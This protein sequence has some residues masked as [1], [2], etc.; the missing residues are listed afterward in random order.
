MGRAVV[1]AVT[2]S[3]ECT[4]AAAIDQGDGLSEL[5]GSDVI[6]DFTTPDAVMATLEYCLKAG[7]HCVVGTTGFDES[8]LAQVKSWCAANPKVGVLIAPNF[9]IGAVLMMHFAEIAAPYFE[10]VEIIELHHPDKVD[11]PSGTAAHTASRIAAARERAGVGPSP[12]ATVHETDHA[13]GAQIDG[14]S[15]HSVRVR[16]LVAHQE[17]LLGGQ[18]ETLTIRQD[19]IDRTSFMPGV[20][21]AV[22][23][24][25]SRPGLTIGLD[26]Y[27]DLSP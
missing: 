19:S 13:R 14:I 11:A 15:V 27:L 6:V 10:S 12:D 16:G 20:L 25:A 7:I 8:R 24:V 1:D 18:G 5:D 26:S 3:P 22:S 17:V 23:K 21:L 4:L 2:A 9:G